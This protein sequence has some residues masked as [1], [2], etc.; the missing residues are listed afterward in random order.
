MDNWNI[1]AGISLVA[2]WAF[3]FV[4]RATRGPEAGTPVE[5]L[6]VIVCLVAVTLSFYQGNLFLLLIYALVA[7][8]FAYMRWRKG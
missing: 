6:I 2:L 8:P 3:W 5:V 4:L 1:V 7:T